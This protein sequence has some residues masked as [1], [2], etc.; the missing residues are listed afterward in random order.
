MNAREKVMRVFERKEVPEGAMWTGHPS[1]DIIPLLADAWK[2]RPDREAV[3][4]YLND[5]IRWIGG[6]NCYHA[7]DGKPAFDYFWNMERGI[8]LSCPGC[9]AECEEIS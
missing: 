4:N 3:F 2:I 1:D 9:F 7:P 5:D 6:V 8:S